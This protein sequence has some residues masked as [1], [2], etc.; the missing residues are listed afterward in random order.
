MVRDKH[1][2]WRQLLAAARLMSP[3]PSEEVSLPS[4]LPSPSSG[5][6]SWLGEMAATLKRGTGG[7]SGRC[8]VTRRVEQVW[9]GVGG[10]LTGGSN[11]ALGWTDSLGRGVSE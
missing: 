7:T 4:H 5:R 3:T 8:W 10:A 6:L 2:E 11:L 1:T 9:E